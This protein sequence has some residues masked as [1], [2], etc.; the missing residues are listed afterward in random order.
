MNE[1]KNIKTGR[2][3]L[4]I[5]ILIVLSVVGILFHDRIASISGCSRTARTASVETKVVPGHVADKIQQGQLS[6]FPA[7]YWNTVE[8]NR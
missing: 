1:E 4:L 3:A 8:D 5:T 6:S 2:A 7:R